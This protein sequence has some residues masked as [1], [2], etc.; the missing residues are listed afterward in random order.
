[1][2]FVS[3]SQAV[4]FRNSDTCVAFEYQLND[5][6]INGA[7]IRLSG[8]YPGQGFAVN[9][10]SKELVYVI[11]GQGTLTVG[12]TSTRLSEGDMALLMPGEKY[13]FDGELVMMMPC[14]PAWT[15]QQHKLVSN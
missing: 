12:E 1:M 7:V 5:P 13:F 3:K 9:E 14:A 6:D 4:E 10:I 15:P 8:R 11:K 2:K